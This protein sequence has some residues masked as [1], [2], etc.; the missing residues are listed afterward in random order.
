MKFLGLRLCE[1][2]S[3]ISY[4]D[5]VSV[6]YYKPE[7]YNQIKVN[8]KKE[9]LIYYHQNL[10]FIENNPVRDRSKV[11]PVLPPPAIK[12]TLPNWILKDV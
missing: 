10:Q 12:M 2:D 1:H 3:N 9:H 6:K 7:R 8:H 11:V 5:G 4:S